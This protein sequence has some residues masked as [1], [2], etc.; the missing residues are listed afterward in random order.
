MAQLDE[1]V[2]ERL[3]RQHLGP[4]E[5]ELLSAR[6]VARYTSS[7]FALY[8]DRFGP[9]DERDVASSFLDMLADRGV[10]HEAEV[11]S[12]EF[13]E[14]EVDE[15]VTLDEGFRRTLEMMEAGVSD[16]TGMPLISTPAGM[17]GIPDILQ[18]RPGAGSVFGDYHYA[19]VEIK[20]AFN[21]RHDQIAHAAF[22]NR[23]LGLIQGFTP[24]TFTLINGRG[25]ERVEEATDWDS[26]LD[27]LLAGARDI[28]FG[29]VVPEP[30]FRRTPWPW[31]SYGDKLAVQVGDV[32]LL[33]GVG[34]VLQRE[35]K[36]AGFATLRDVALA[37]EDDLL[38]VG[39]VGASKVDYLRPKAKALLDRAPIA[40]AGATHR[41]PEVT[42]EVF[43][44]FEGTNLLPGTR[45]DVV[46]YLI[47]VVARSR[48]GQRYTPF[49]ARTPSDEGLCL[50][51]FCQSIASAGTVVIYHWGVYERVHLEKMMREYRIRLKVRA[52][53]MAS[54][55][56]LSRIA[57][58]AFAFPSTDDTLKGIARSL[59]FEWR[60]ADVAALDTMVLYHAY[61]G[62]GSTD[63][64]L[65]ESILTYNEDDCLA[66][67]AIRDWLG[68]NL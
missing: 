38:K 24:L 9:R 40:R 61:V 14:A 27:T 1:G 15:Y 32:S 23:L 22:Y 44:D 5:Q 13:P 4:T 34:P 48:D 47:G 66:T 43:L 11:V 26:A 45:L 54:L 42:T 37:D 64:G 35:L 39:G 18:K 57:T 21:L 60:L 33:P 6:D 56:D 52:Q 25:E 28:A 29:R 17:Y 7:P 2:V 3:L 55:V 53:V 20:L 59:G 30:T 19:V 63:E 58:R 49:F 31:G 50:R 46:N 8:C 62:S 36:I 10:A 16:I 12:E 65:R 67:L 68:A 51:Q 41:F